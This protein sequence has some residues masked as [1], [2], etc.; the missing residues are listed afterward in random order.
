MDPGHII[1]KLYTTTI[2]QWHETKHQFEQPLSLTKVLFF[3]Q[4]VFSHLDSVVHV[5]AITLVKVK[6]GTFEG[7]PSSGSGVG[8]VGL[9]PI[10]RSKDRQLVLQRW[11]SRKEELGFRLLLSRCCCCYRRCSPFGSLTLWRRRR[12][13]CRSLYSTVSDWWIRSSPQ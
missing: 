7:P 9:S 4:Q 1:V 3:H 5:W 8:H 10:S 13:R 6:R 2:V 11:N 12:S